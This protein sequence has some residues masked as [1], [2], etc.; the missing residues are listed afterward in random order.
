MFSYWQQDNATR[1][2]ALYTSNW[3]DDE[4]AMK[5][6][7]VNCSDDANILKMAEKNKDVRVYKNAKNDEERFEVWSE[8]YNKEWIEN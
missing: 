7:V 2:L 8:T 5:S 4:I 1:W 6:V 3:K